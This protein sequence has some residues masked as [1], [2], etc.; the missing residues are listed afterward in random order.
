MDTVAG[1]QLFIRV[2][3]TG[4]FSKASA[5]LGIT[6]PTATKHVA[7]LEARLG[8]RLFHRSTRGVTPTEVGSAYYD[9]CKAIVREIDEADNLAALMQSRVQG[10]LRISTSVAFGRRVLT[11]LVLRY[12]HAHPGVQIDLSFD[13]RYV[14]L[15]EQGVDVAVRMGRLAD[16]SLGARCLGLNPWV[17]V[18]APGYLQRRGVP[19][20]PAELGSHDALIYSSVQ[21]D[22]RWHFSGA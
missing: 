11:P 7:A 5:D 21:G 4:S 12:M 20:T 14:N 10:S 18:G 22:E 6:Q 3:E 8:A 15:V 1:L 19:A 17:L 9:K 2:I 16:S 13:D